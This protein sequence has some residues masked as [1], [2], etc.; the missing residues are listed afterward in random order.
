MRSALADD[1]NTAQALA[2]VFDMVRDA[3]TIA[4][5]N[6]LRQDDKA[7]LLEALRQFDEIFAVL[8]D[9]D[10][11]K[12]TRAAEWAKARG[13][14]TADPGELISDADVERLIAERTAAKKGRDFAKADAIRTQ[15][16][17]AGIVV[18]DTKDGIRWKR[19]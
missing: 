9:D 14:A 13:I 10:A 4:D 18:E 11:E 19:K 3:N 2:A 8:K 16:A 7:P 15:L 1:L 5:K 12:M 6:E 17:E